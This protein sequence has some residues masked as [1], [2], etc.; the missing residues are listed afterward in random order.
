MR[1]SS[2]EIQF[3]STHREVKRFVRKESISERIRRPNVHPRVMK[4]ETDSFEEP[5]SRLLMDREQ[6]RNLVG[7]PER[8][9]GQA[10]VRL[11]S[12]QAIEGTRRSTVKSVEPVE[13]MVPEALELRVEDRAQIDM[14]VAAVEQVS[15]KRM[16]LVDPEAILKEAYETPDTSE[17]EV[18]QSA[19]EVSV[20]PAPETRIREV[21]YQYYESYY[22][23]ESTTFEA[24][25]VVKTADGQEIS[26]GVSLSMSR[27]FMR[28]VEIDVMMEETVEVKD[29]LI[30]NFGGTAA[31]L[32]QRKFAFDIDMDG[33]ADQVHFAGPGSGF[34][35][36]DRNG[37]G[38]IN[39][40]G[41]LFGARTGNG[42]GEL[43]ELDTDGNG[44]IDEND[45]VYESLRIFS[46][47]EFGNDRLVGLGQ[48]GVGAIF[49][50]H[51]TTPFQMK[52]EQNALQGLVRSSGIFLSEDG[53][54]G[55]VQQVDLVV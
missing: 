24:E 39:D 16:M 49:L 26:I 42:F 47:D 23:A 29:P 43:A 7:L 51:V 50:G 9:E 4:K 8:F 40:G 6:D 34:L 28:E 31:E 17:L 25:G 35:A 53:G 46:K 44:W 30:I 20:E 37:D 15:G 41:E 21:R 48:R 14:I 55:T 33:Q 18:L 45:S 52:N 10:A 27:E 38:T 11:Q 13:G 5:G 1:I 22:E 2:S 36:L 19:Q 32:T 12:R 3:A 54:V